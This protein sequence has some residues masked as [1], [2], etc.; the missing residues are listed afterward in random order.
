ARIGVAVGQG[1]YPVRIAA[2]PKHPFVGVA[3]EIAMVAEYRRL[4]DMR[5]GR[6]RRQILG[7]VLAAVDDVHALDRCSAITGYGAGGQQQEQRPNKF[8]HFSDLHHTI[9]MTLFLPA[10][11]K[12]KAASHTA[13][14]PSRMTQISTPCPDILA[15]VWLSCHPPCHE[16]AMVWPISA[17]N[18]LRT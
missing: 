16:F 10:S 1:R 8:F 9:P 11:L 15:P 14:L 5:A 17:C 2:I 6:P 7:V 4:A 18:C 3:D 13:I 12:L